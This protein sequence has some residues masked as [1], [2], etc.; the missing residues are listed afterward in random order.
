MSKTYYFNRNKSFFNLKFFKFLKKAWT[1]GS[2]IFGSKSQFECQINSE[3]FLKK[4]Q[5]FDP[6][7]D[8]SLCIIDLS[9]LW[10]LP[11]ALGPMVLG[12]C[13]WESS[14]DPSQESI[15]QRTETSDPNSKIQSQ[16]SQNY[17]SKTTQTRWML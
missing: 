8:S 1:R 2:P 5:D 7:S 12:I 13:M 16:T 3:P 6:T 9:I 15:C 14:G 17:Q 11:I 10:S 4:C